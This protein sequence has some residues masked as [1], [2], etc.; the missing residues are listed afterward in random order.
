MRFSNLIST[1]EQK[2]IG[3]VYDVELW[4]ADMLAADQNIEDLD[5]PERSN[6]LVV[7]LSPSVQDPGV[8]WVGLENEIKQQ[9]KARAF[10]EGYVESGKD[11]LR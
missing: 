11:F 9:S 7:T 1:I 10:Y 4:A 8:F 6:N 2:N 3:I 5:V